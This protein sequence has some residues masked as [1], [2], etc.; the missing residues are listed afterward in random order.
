MFRPATAD[1]LDLYGLLFR[2][3]NSG[4]L[5]EKIL[6]MS[7]KSNSEKKSMIIK[8][9]ELVENNYDVEIVVNKYNQEIYKI[10]KL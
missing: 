8:A 7:S 2:V 5:V 9:R 4:D 1:T 10:F 6:E 3:K